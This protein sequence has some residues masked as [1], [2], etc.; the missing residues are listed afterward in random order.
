MNAM[1]LT[2]MSSVTTDRRPVVQRG[3]NGWMR[4]EPMGKKFS[5]E[6][7]VVESLSAGKFGFPAIFIGRQPFPANQRHAGI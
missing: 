5:A 6:R 4:G 2:T 1:T 3:M 7:A